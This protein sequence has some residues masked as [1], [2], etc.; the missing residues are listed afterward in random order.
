MNPD[1]PMSWWAACG[2]VILAVLL[3]FL[4]AV[5][6]IP[7]EDL[8]PLPTSVEVVPTLDETLVPT[9]FSSR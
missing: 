2:V 8:A 6:G 1:A 3:G 9:Y 7:D 4:F 5:A